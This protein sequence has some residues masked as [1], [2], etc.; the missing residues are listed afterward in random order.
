[1]DELPE[2]IESDVRRHAR[3]AAETL[4]FWTKLALMILLALLLGVLL[5]S[6]CH[7]RAAFHAAERA[8]EQASMAYAKRAMAGQPVDPDIAKEKDRAE[9]RYVAASRR[10]RYYFAWLLRDPALT[11]H[12]DD[13]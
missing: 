6:A 8:Y 9:Q 7:E 3:R 5:P 2:K 4:R 11:A 1:M 10:Y 13:H 12:Q